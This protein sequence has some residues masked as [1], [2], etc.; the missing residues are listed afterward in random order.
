MS[1]SPTAKV[2]TG[3]EAVAI[4]KEWLAKL[5]LNPRNNQKDLDSLARAIER[6]ERYYAK[7]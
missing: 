4:E 5:R 3:K 6:V 2:Y 1:E 7:R